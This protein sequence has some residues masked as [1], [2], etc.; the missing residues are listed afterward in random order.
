[1]TPGKRREKLH[2]Q[3]RGVVEDD[4]GNEVSGPFATVF[5]EYAELM[6]LK[7]GESVLA[8]RLSGVQPFIIR[9][10]GS[11]AARDVT[12]AWRAVDARNPSRIFNITSVANFDQK[13]AGIDMMATQ[14]V[15]T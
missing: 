13:N 4:Y 15:V 9:I 2:F 7:G 3:S 5:T 1:M 10:P 6:P 14:G 8:S 11:T 12:T